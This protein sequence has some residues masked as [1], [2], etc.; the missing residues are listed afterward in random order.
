MTLVRDYVN[1]SEVLNELKLKGSGRRFLLMIL[2]LIII[3]LAVLWL[4]P[5]VQTAYGIG[6]V[7]TLS[8]QDR[9]QAISAL[10]P[11]QIKEWHVIEGQRVKKGQI[12]VTLEDQDPNLI[13]RLKLRLNAVEQQREAAE[14]SAKAAEQE[15][16]RKQNL[17]DQGIT[18]A[19]ERDEAQIKL[20]DS[21]TKL[22]SIDADLNAARTALSRQSTQTKRAPADGVITRLVA[23]GVA[24]SVK[25]GD[26]L[27]SFVPDNV[28]RSVV[29][30]VSGL[31]APLIQPDLPVRLQFD[32]WPVFQFSG[33]PSQAIGTFG[34]YV[35]FVEPVANAQGNFNVWVHEDPKE[36]WPNSDF[37]RLGS[38]AKGWVLLGEV[39]LGYEI[40]R[41]L[42]NFPPLNPNA[43]SQA[44]QK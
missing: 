4:T 37:V 20:Q 9:T 16:K 6:T 8:A 19:R 15:L 10:V 11:G 30:E 32:G 36:P 35:S 38:R 44:S 1:K 5:W 18:S 31:D 14:I 3:G 29:I 40:W 13:A 12:I 34:G 28:T 26:M 21:L 41:Q 27:A 25:T 23:G 39:K 2:L 17:L 7:S 22:A 42:N 43:T 24:T 33:W